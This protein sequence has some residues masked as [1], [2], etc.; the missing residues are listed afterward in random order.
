MLSV[1]H[2]HLYLLKEVGEPEPGGG[3]GA[4]S[5]LT[6]SGP[7]KW[8]FHAGPVAIGANTQ[9]ISQ[10]TGIAAKTDV[11]DKNPAENRPV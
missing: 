6:P 7:S 10:I 1:P 11:L 9:E 8:V 5:K 4:P 2:F 3:A